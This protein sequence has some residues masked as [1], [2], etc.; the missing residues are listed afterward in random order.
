[1]GQ[2]DLVKA[3]L[4]KKNLEYL[5]RKSDL[6]WE[7]L[8]EG[9]KVS[10]PTLRRVYDLKT[11]LSKSN[12]NKVELFFGL[13]QNTIEKAV[14]KSIPE[15]FSNAPFN[16]FKN[17][18]LGNPSFFKS[19]SKASKAAEFVRKEILKDAYFKKPL[20]KK[21]MIERLKLSKKYKIIYSDFAMAKE[22]ERLY[23]EDK[24]LDVEDK[25]ENASIFYY[26]RK[27]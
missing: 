13:P 20:Q 15:N 4:V 1:M 25:H 5:L 7:G 6:T 3:K 10:S 16:N 2:I 24:I 18:N 12:R 26:Y 14:L 17:A 23:K 21:V 11:N 22:I 27:E 19:K 8:A 9:S